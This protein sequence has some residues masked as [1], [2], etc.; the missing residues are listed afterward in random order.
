MCLHLDIS[1]LSQEA[2]VLLL[3]ASLLLNIHQPKG[4]ERRREGLQEQAGRC[5]DLW[6]SAPCLHGPQSMRA[7]EQLLSH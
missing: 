7:G 6:P 5:G 2:L 4:S 1:L 3:Q